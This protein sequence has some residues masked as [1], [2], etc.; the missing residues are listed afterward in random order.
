MAR[1]ARL[2]MT[3]RLH[4]ASWYTAAATTVVA[5]A[6]GAVASEAPTKSYAEL[7]RLDFPAL[8]TALEQAGWPEA[9]VRAFVGAEIQRRLNPPYTPTD[10]DLRPFE[11][12]RTGPDAEP[13][14]TTDL[15]RRETDAARRDTEVRETFDRLFPTA[16]PQES[17]AL[18]RWRELREWGTLAADKRAAITARLTRA[19]R[20]RAALLQP[21][22]GMLTRAEWT[23]VWQIEDEARR[24]VIQ[25]LTPAE[26]LDYD[27]RTSATANRLR[28]DLDAFRP[29]RD[30]FL[31]IFRAQLDFDLR[32]AQKP[33]G[34]DPAVDQARTEAAAALR[35]ALAAALGPERFADYEL[36]LEPGCQVLA[37]DA[38]F[39]NVDAPAVRALYRRVQA[40]RRALA[41]AIKAPDAETKA[42][43]KADLYREFRRLFD[44]ESTRRY[45]QEQALW[46]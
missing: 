18:A 16:D 5:A 19:E 10:R 33:P 6:L 40:C 23:R 3:L 1:H 36:S 7:S 37:F 43:L 42:R 28:H 41:D 14:A 2:R 15:R 26:L 20:D 38:R 9:H 27:L 13:I 45:L 32:F 17:P 4:R 29:S 22:G 21:R 34:I 31:A 39:A 35:Q 46:P 44:E 25:L 11:F 24:D 8:K 12:W 30:E